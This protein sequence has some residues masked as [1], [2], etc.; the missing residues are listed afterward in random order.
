MKQIIILLL[1]LLPIT[2]VYSQC[3]NDLSSANPYYPG[4]WVPGLP[5]SQKQ[6]C[7]TDLNILSKN[8][9]LCD[10]V[11]FY[12]TLSSC[13]SK[14][15]SASEQE[16]CLNPGGGGSGGGGGNTSGSGKWYAIQAS[17]KCSKDCPKSSSDAD[18]GGLQSWGD[19]FS[20]STDCCNT[21]LSNVV[22]GLCESNSQS[23]LPKYV[24]SSKWYTDGT[25]CVKDCVKDGTNLECGGV[26]SERSV[27]LY[28]SLINGGCCDLGLAWLNVDVCKGNSGKFFLCVIRER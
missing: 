7:L 13:C 27:K 10:S 1:L 22:L 14:Y 21:S 19:K 16:N 5:Q 8:N 23:S 12:P 28:D 3:A 6:T 4:L 26:I 24:G 15:Y 25:K 2:T 18:C 11:Q 9:W 20:T 17:S